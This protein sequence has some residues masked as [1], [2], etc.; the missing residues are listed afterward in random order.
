MIGYCFTTIVL[1][2]EALFDSEE[3]AQR[4]RFCLGSVEG[5]VE[6]IIEFM[7]EELADTEFLAENPLQEEKVPVS[8][9]QLAQSIFDF[10]DVETDAP[11]DTPWT[12]DEM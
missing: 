10:L 11:H 8:L 12:P 1:M 6:Q 9:R 7:D 2:I 3:S 4:L 5:L